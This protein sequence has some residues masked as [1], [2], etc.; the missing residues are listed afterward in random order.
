[1][2]IKRAFAVLELRERLIFKLAVLAGLRPGEIFGLRRTRLSENTADI[3][4]RI[5]RGKLDTPKTQKSIR[6]VALSA[7]VREDLENWLAVSPTGR[8]GWLFPS[9]KLDTPLS[10]DNALY[11]YIRPRLKAVGLDWVDFQVMRRTHSSLMRELGIDPKIVA[12]LMGHDVNVNLNVYTQ[13]SVESRLQ[14]VETLE[15]AFVN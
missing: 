11:R 2:K 15:T 13:T 14:A 8:E 9:E 5:Y 12:D 1:M 3:Q 6:V 7:S 4:E 10:K